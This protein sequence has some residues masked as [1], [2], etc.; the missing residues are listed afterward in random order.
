MTMNDDVWR[1]MLIDYRINSTGANLCDYNY[2]TKKG[3]QVKPV[4]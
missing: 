1:W 3:K 4:W 2:N